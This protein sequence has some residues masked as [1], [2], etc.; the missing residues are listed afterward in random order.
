MDISVIIAAGDEL[1]LLKESICAADLAC[2]GLG[3]ELIVVDNASRD[4]TSDWLAA[5]YPQTKV[6]RQDRRI[7]LSEARNRGIAESRGDL[8]LFLDSDT[9]LKPEAARML[10]RFM[11]NHP[12]VGIAGPRITSPDGTFQ[13]S[14]RG[15]QTWSSFVRRGLRRPPRGR[16]RLLVELAR[17]ATRPIPVDWV[18]G[19]C[20]IVR[21]QAVEDVGPMDEGFRLYYGDVEWCWRMMHHGWKVCY[22]PSAECVHHYR[23]LSARLPPNRWTIVHIRDFLRFRRRARR[24]HSHG[25][26]GDG[27]GKIRI[28]YLND[29]VEL[30]GPPLQHAKI[31]RSLNRERF[32][33]VAYVE[34]VRGRGD[35]ELA[36]EVGLPLL[37]FHKRGLLDKYVRIPLALRRMLR[38]TRIDVVHSELFKMNLLAAFVGLI[39]R[40]ATVMSISISY[41]RDPR[42][43]WWDIACLKAALKLADRTVLNADA[44]RRYC[45]N[46]YGA[47]PERLRVVY[48]G[49]DLSE[50]RPHGMLSKQELSIPENGRA[51]VV[52]ARLEPQKGHAVLLHALTLLP[53]ELGSVVALFVGDGSQRD[54]LKAEAH[55]IGVADRVRFLGSRRDIPDILSL[56]DLFVLPSFFEGMPLAVMEAMASGVPVVATDVD[57]T[58]ELIE[59][60]VTGMLVKPGNSEDLARVVARLLTHREIARRLAQAAR[61]KVQ[62]SFATERMVRE[63]E[64]VY[65]EA[66]AHARKR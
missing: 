47:P 13:E 1:R 22:V 49:L 62:V 61:R 4:G 12:D 54:G 25:R 10:L 23:R 58:R 16:D 51:I 5:V 34:L 59:D 43:S 40:T 27:D 57:G 44:L 9:R 28:L 46:H 7:G 15:Y 64:Q 17:K 26:R 36:Q 60:G 37:C 52:V 31:V 24:L 45:I 50:L 53:Q 8:L 2:A 18:L 6:L 66:L 14:C 55:R 38:S 20:Q 11:H 3:H 33:P 63:T 42:Y 65:E 41:D 39:T 29:V 56:S 35:E 19:A 30:S 48:Y 21:R 32:E